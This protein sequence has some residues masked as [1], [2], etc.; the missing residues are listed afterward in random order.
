VLSLCR[1]REVPFFCDAAQW[2]GK[3]PKKSLGHCDF[4]IDC[5]HKFGR[6]KG[7]S[8]LKCPA[9]VC[10][11]PFLSVAN[12][13]NTGVPARRMWRAFSRWWRLWL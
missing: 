3:L 10:V 4:V 1:E 12:R 9:K 2:I 7:V 8:F 6:P 11:E 13:K 5:V